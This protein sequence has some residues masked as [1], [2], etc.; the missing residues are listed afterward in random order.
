MPL[1]GTGGGQHHHAAAQLTRDAFRV[2]A[3]PARFAE[4]GL[5]AWQARKLYEGGIGGFGGAENAAGVRVPT[6]TSTTRSSA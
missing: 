3:D 4:Q 2:A 6:G 1:Q 5:P